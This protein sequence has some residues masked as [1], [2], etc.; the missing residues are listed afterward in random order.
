MHYYAFYEFLMGLLKP[1][2]IVFLVFYFGMII[3]PLFATVSYLVN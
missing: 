1:D 3:F 2:L